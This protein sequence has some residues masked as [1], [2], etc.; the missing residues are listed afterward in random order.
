MQHIIA[1]A[2]LPKTWQGIELNGQNVGVVIIDTEYHFCL[3]RLASILENRI[4]YSVRTNLAQT[5]SKDVTNPT[6]GDVDK[7]IKEC[8]HRLY[9]VRCNSTTQLIMS[10]YSLDSLLSSNLDIALLVVDS[11]SAFYWMDRGVTSDS[12]SAKNSAQQRT[13][14]ALQHIMDTYGIFTVITRADIFPPKAR[15]EDSDMKD[16]QDV[17]QAK[18]TEQWNYLGRPWQQAISCTY[19]LG[20]SGNIE[21]EPTFVLSFV[22]PGTK[23]VSKLQFQVTNCGLQYLQ[24]F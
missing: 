11:A 20:L 3:L 10:L 5:E 22:Q 16:M 18:Q 24:C 13:L 8:L 21:N 2:I 15:E 7:L 12:T 14:R 23:S 17:M 19:N 6:E 9:V 1:N 4:N